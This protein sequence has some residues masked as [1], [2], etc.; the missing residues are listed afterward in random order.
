M[1]EGAEAD[2]LRAVARAAI[3]AELSGTPAP[4]PPTGGALD[5]RCGVFVTLR[6]GDRLRG[7]IG[8]IEG[9][10]PLGEAIVALAASAAFRDR[11]FAPLCADELEDLEVEL[12]VLT[13]PEPADVDG[14]VIGRHGLWVRGRGRQGV[15]LPS[16]AAERGWD[17]ETFLAETCRKAG[18]P[19]DAWAASDVEVRWVR[20]VRRLEELYT[21]TGEPRS[22]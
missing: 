7:C 18:L 4:T 10:R 22:E 15:L 1:L 9:R 6:R 17:P 8:Q 20:D 12:T 14:R 16:V 21:T 19:E 11:R 5:R 3:Q 2:R 13:P